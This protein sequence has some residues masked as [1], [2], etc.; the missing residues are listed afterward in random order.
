MTRNPV[1][2]R[3]RDD[4]PATGTARTPS[5]APWRDDD[6]TVPCPVC[7]RLFTPAGRARYCGDGCRKTAWRRR[8]Q[9]L[10]A[11]VVVPA[12]IARR[13]VTVYQCAGCGTRSVGRQRCQDCGAFMARVGFGGCCPH[14]EQPVA[15]DELLDL[16]PS[17]AATA[18]L[19]DRD[20]TGRA[21]T[22]TG[23]GPRR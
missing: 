6:A 9:V 3:Q 20:G 1:T 7:A 11:P 10:P 22:K 4:R 23:T 5:D 21:A 16:P 8:H 15:V 17:A 2:R 14:C 19:P 12:P 18:P 13:P